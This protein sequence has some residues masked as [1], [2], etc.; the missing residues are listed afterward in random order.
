MRAQPRW[1][2]PTLRLDDWDGFWEIGL[3]EWDM[4]GG[5]L[6]VQ[7]DRLVISDFSGGNDFVQSGNISSADNRFKALLQEMQPHL[8]PALA[9]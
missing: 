2:W 6:L 7:E 1:I 8:T 4:A 9:R 3:K 5:A